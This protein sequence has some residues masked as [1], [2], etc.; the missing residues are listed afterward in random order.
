MQFNFKKIALLKTHSFSCIG[1]PACAC[2]TQSLWL[3]GLNGFSGR[4][5][6]WLVPGAEYAV[7]KKQQMANGDR[8]ADDAHASSAAL[9]EDAE[10]LGS[11]LHVL[12]VLP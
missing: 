5:E 2:L 7:S 1:S 3:K 10:G 6:R 9:L 11:L 4:A 8:C 12:I